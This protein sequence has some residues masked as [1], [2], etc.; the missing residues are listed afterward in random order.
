[1]GRLRPV[2]VPVTTC[3]RDASATWPTLRVVASTDALQRRRP[4]I[5]RAAMAR[6]ASSG[7]GLPGDT[8]QYVDPRAPVWPPQEQRR[9]GQWW[10]VLVVKNHKRRAE[11]LPP[12]FGTEKS[13]ARY[14]RGTWQY[15]VL[16]FPLAIFA[17]GVFLGHELR[18]ALVWQLVVTF[19]F[20]LDVA[21][22]S[23]RRPGSWERQFSALMA[24][25]VLPAVLAFGFMQLLF[26][27]RLLGACCIGVFLCTAGYRQI[28]NRVGRR[29]AERA[30][31][32]LA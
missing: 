21:L 14:D 16:R 30:E 19:A 7:T 3:M 6:R 12:L 32:D 18:H 31:L 5:N 26:G 13:G 10:R 23:K 22:T 4:C 24:V 2:P 20:G 8:G 9:W 11:L 1:M 17:G 27:N 15:W 28:A 29:I 25:S